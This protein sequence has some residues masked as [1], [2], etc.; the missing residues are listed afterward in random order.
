MDTVEADAMV[1]I[2]NVLE[3]AVPLLEKIRDDIQEFTR[4]QSEAFEL[5]KS[6]EDEM[7]RAMSGVAMDDA[8]DIL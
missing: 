2:A 5:M 7:R 8:R 4:V 1:R 6:R 3:V